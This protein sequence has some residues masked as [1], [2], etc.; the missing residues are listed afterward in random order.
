M[1]PPVCLVSVLGTSEYRQSWDCQVTL[2]DAVRSR[3]APNTLLLLEHP[4]LYTRGRLSKPEHILLAADELEARGIA[5]YD[6]DRGG[7]VTFH[8]PGQLVGYPVIDVRAGGGPL[9]YVRT[10][11]QII[12]ATVA[13]CGVIAGVIDGITGVWAGEAKI[14]AIG[15]K[16]S[17][18][19]AYHGFAINVNTDLSY[20]DYIVPCGIEDLSVTSMAQI[21]SQQVEMDTVQ[22]S[23][24]YQFGKAMGFRMVESDPGVAG[25]TP[26]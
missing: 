26:F 13:D 4:P 20:F 3:Q 11:E 24:T 23:L 19:V 16:I 1:P 5:V 15:V 18:G 25:L 7:Q 12:V 10:L 21:L 17:R 6:A 14:A 8:G 22:Y 2:A 9:K